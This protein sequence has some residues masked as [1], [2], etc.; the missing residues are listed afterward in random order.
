MIPCAPD[1]ARP[2]VRIKICGVTQAEEAQACLA[3]GAHLIGLNF[4]PRS[5]RYLELPRAA[6]IVAALE[7]PERAVGVFVDRPPKEVAATASALGLSTVQ[8]HGNEPPGH[9]VE[10]LPLNVIRAFRIGIPADLNAL[11]VYLRHTHELGRPPYAVLIDAYVS[12]LEGGTGVTI[13]DELLSELMSL[14]HLILAGGLTAENVAE[15]VERIRPWMVDV[16][17]GVESAPGRKDL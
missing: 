15:R 17:S 4:H 8:L 6:E 1:L 16:A 2:A 3:A 9:L 11:S 14:P 7:R 5:P 12:G 10:L 13:A